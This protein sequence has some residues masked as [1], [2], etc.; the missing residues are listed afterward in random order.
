MRISNW[1]ILFLM[2]FVGMTL[3]VDLH[4]HY[5]REAQITMESYNRILDRAA[6]DAL[7]DQLLEE[8]VD[9]SLAVAEEAVQKHFLEQ[10][11]F[12]FDLTTEYERERVEELVLLQE[13]VNEREELSDAEKNRIRESMEQAIAERSALDYMT[14]ALLLP[15]E[16]GAE[17]TQNLKNHGFYTFLELPDKRDYR[18]TNL[19]DMEKVRYALSGA[20]L[21]KKEED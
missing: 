10:T 17:W 5:A 18:W 14:Y 20:Q 4:Y 7:S 2:L 21:K 11:A 1:C 12:V 8:Y 6:E 9:G 13:L 3:G 19:F 15:V 16:D